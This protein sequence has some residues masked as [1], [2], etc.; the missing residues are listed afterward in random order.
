MDG[1]TAAASS[2]KERVR[3]VAPDPFTT[4]DRDNSTADG[5]FTIFR[6]A[7]P[8]TASDLLPM[9]VALPATATLTRTAPALV[10]AATV[11]V[12]VPLLLAPLATTTLDGE[13]VTPV[14]VG[15]NVIVPPTAAVFSANDTAELAPPPLVI[16]TAAESEIADGPSITVT[17]L[18]PSTTNGELPMLLALPVSATLML[19][20]PVLVPAPAVITKVWLVLAPFVTVTLDGE[21]ITPIAVGVSVMLPPAAGVLMVNDTAALAAPPSTT[22]TVFDTATDETDPCFGSD[23]MLM[24]H[25][26]WKV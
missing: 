2:K 12:N 18:P 10:P 3:L 24:D 11:A 21:K 16:W 5:A 20:A 8:V 15:V 13:N 4:T 19:T 25:V 23:L 9:L 26:R 17:L 14:A 7:M 6:I 22:C 1:P